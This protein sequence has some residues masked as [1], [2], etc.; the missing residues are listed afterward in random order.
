MDSTADVTQ[1]DEVIPTD[2][3]TE[4]GSALPLPAEAAAE[5]RQKWGKDRDVSLE[6]LEG[7]SI[8]EQFLKI[9]GTP[10]RGEILWNFWYKAQPE[11]S[12]GFLDMM[13]DNLVS[14]IGCTLEE[15][16]TRLA[17]DKFLSDQGPNVATNYVDSYKAR[18]LR[19]SRSL[20]PL[21]L[22]KKRKK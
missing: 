3:I 22:A 12:R 8:A 19:N 1:A 2:E 21:Q 17:V 4:V 10:E 20:K 15:A 7:L 14:E 6:E 18:K 9:W 16:H 5:L 11:G 13:A